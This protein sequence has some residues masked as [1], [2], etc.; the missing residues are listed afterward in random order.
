M[1]IPNSCLQ[2]CVPFVFVCWTTLKSAK[3]PSST[4]TMRKKHEKKVE[5][6]PSS[7][8]K[9]SLKI[10][11]VELWCRRPA[12]VKLGQVWLLMSHSFAYMGEAP[13]LLY[14]DVLYTSYTTTISPLSV[15]T[16]C[17]SSTLK[18]SSP[19]SS[20]SST[21]TRLTDG[22]DLSCVIVSPSLKG[23]TNRYNERNVL[24]TTNNSYYEQQ[25]RVG[26]YMHVVVVSPSR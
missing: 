1:L 21:L 23:N 26:K 3:Y 12:A 19:P 7:T 22:G 10:Y 16:G 4:L 20:S 5:I 15:W 14:I 2:Y 9:G 11:Q 17:P 24:S 13:T 6:R 8:L 25:Q 18:G